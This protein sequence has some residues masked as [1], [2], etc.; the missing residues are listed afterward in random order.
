MQQRRTFFGL[1][2]LSS[3]LVF[4]MAWVIYFQQRSAIRKLISETFAISAREVASQLSVSV[5][6]NDVHGIKRAL[7]KSYL[8]SNANFVFVNRV[9]QSLLISIPDR[10]L[11]LPPENC[12]ATL[13]NTPIEFD[14]STV[15]YLGYC[16]DFDRLAQIQ[17]PVYLYLALFL[18]I[19]IVSVLIWLWYRAGT[20]RTDAFVKLFDSIDP[21]RPVLDNVS[22]EQKFKHTSLE[23]LYKKLDLFLVELHNAAL[24]RKQQELERG[25]LKLSQQVSHDIRS[26]ISALQIL[27]N[28]LGEVEEDKRTI[29]RHSLN[30]ITEIANNLDQCR[31]IPTSGDTSIIYENDLTA[32]STR[33]LTSCL[34]SPI[35]EA[36]VTE[37][38]LQFSK[39]EDLSITYCVEGNP[40]F[41][42]AKIDISE[43]KRALSNLMNNSVEAIRGTGTV[44]VCL[45]FREGGLEIKIIDSGIGIS[46]EIIPLLAK[47]G[48]SHRKPGGSGLGLHHARKTIEEHGGQMEIQSEKGKGTTVSIR[49]P[50]SERPS[51]FVPTIEVSNGFDIVVL[52]D[53]ETIHQVWDH[54]VSQAGLEHAVRV[55]HCSNPAEFEVSLSKLEVSRQEGRFLALVD[56]DLHDERYTGLS[57]VRKHDL[58]RAAILVTSHYDSSEIYDVCIELG[59][60]LIPKSL[61][62]SVPIAFKGSHS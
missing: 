29:L 39:R 28:D 38:R 61:A 16:Y 3:L 25:Y 42:Y 11:S 54:R 19:V 18:A 15:G 12:G 30:R 8:A 6:V 41:S 57:L 14:G 31:Y 17:I 1:V 44:E 62:A 34:L 45:F 27:L 47:R 26:P 36:V 7:S 10:E 48:Y 53:D 13:G 32:L 52:D 2:A 56:Y 55:H 60:G 59:V 20:Y 49:L 35:L 46:P 40:Y 33:P 50:Q 51:W 4:A 37:K 22:W 21:Q 24:K 23:P 9:D 5:K 43:V 58:R